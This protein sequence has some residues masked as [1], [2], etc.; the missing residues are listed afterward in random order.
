MPITQVIT[1]MPTAPNPATDTSA[2]FSAK[3][4]AFTVAQAAMG[5]ELNTMVTQANTLEANVTAKEASA[6]ASANSAAASMTTATAQAT[7]ATTKAADA[8]ASAVSAVN[9]PGTS[10]TS[11]TSL[12]LGTGT[13]TFTTQTGKAWVVGQPVNISRTSAPTVSAMYGLITAYTSGTGA[14]SVSIASVADVTGSGTF[15]D[16]TIAL[17][18]PKGTATLGGV[19]SSTIDH[20]TG[21]AIA[22]AATINLD[23]ASGNRVHITGTTTITAVTLTRGPRMVVFDGMLTLAYNA[24]T[25]RVTGGA[26]IITAPGDICHY[27]SDGTTV[28]GNYVKADGTA[29]TGNTA[30]LLGAA[31]TATV[32]EAAASAGFV[33]VC[34]LSSTRAIGIYA[35]AGQPKGV[36]LDNTGAVIATAVIEAAALNAG[37]SLQIIALTST[38]A[39]AIYA[40]GTTLR[41]VVLSDGGAS[42]TVGT[43]VTLAAVVSPKQCLIGLTATKVIAAFQDNTNNQISGVVLGISGAAITVNAG[44]ILVAGNGATLCI[45]GA[46]ISSTQVVLTYSQLTT[47]ILYLQVLTEAAN[48]LT[49]PAPSQF[50]TTGNQNTEELVPINASRVGLIL[51]SGSVTAQTNAAL[52]IDVSG[53]GAAAKVQ[54][55]KANPLAILDTNQATGIRGLKLSANTILATTVATGFGMALQPFSIRGPNLVPGD[56]A[57]I[58]RGAGVNDICLMGTSTVLVVYADAANSNYPTARVMALGT[59]T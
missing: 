38:T 58:A 28:Y 13:Q 21:A 56:G 34:A 4:Q 55:G 20:L 17:V 52:T 5:G 3:A 53:T 2:T 12:T 26:D 7:I 31:G 33:A 45:R 57:N 35:S 11:T 51:N 40:L 54:F 1:A 29:I 23:T 15:T 19:A 47:A 42:V 9:A 22:S 16:W 46:A 25:N 32:I 6:T 30:P 48:V 10:G 43:P 50:A 36:I 8:A 49:F 18:G 24:T 59:V 41:S 37:S 14:M 27:N 44:A 39:I